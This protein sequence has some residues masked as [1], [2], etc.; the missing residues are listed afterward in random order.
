MNIFKLFGCLRQDIHHSRAWALAV[1]FLL[2]ASFVP[3]K[4]GLAQQLAP[5]DAEPMHQPAAHLMASM[6][7][8]LG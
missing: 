2:D 5:H 1:L 3:Q 6:G 7:F 8:G 4:Q